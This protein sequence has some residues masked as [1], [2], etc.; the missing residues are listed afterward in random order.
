MGF[1][2]AAFF[3]SIVLIFVAP[4]VGILALLLTFI[5]VVVAICVTILGW[6]FWGGKRKS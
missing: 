3:V 5:W 6:G 2:L 4:S 1:A